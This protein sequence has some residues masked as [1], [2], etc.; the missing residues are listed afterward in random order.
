MSKSERE[1][2]IQH[3]INV[4]KKIFKKMPCG[5]RAPSNIID[6]EQMKLLQDKG[7]LYDSSIV[8]RFPFFMKYRGYKKKAPIIPYHPSYNDCRKRGNMSILEIPT[9]GLILGIPLWGG[10]LRYIPFNVYRDLF[11]VSC[12]AFLNLAMHSWDA[13]SFR[14]VKFKNSGDKFIKILDKM[15]CLLK[16]KDYE[17]M[18]GRDIAQKFS[19]VQN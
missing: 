17:F 10:S 11:R 8:P 19:K 16:A 7:F 9:S 14:D 12:P 4:Y 6:E 13:V 15:I 5:F 18:S 3:Y 2:D 1:Q